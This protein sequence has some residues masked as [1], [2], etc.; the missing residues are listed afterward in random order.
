[1]LTPADLFLVVI[2]ILM[3]ILSVA[4]VVQNSPAKRKGRRDND[5]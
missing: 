5:V 2:V 1:M 3:V 4:L